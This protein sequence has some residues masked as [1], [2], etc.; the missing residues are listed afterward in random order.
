LILQAANGAGTVTM[1]FISVSDCQYFYVIGVNIVS[2]N[3]ADALSVIGCDHVLFKSCTIDGFDAENIVLAQNV[4][5]FSS[6]SR[7][8]LED[9]ILTRANQ[10]LLS[11]SGIHYGHVLR[12]KLDSTAGIGMIVT[13]GSAYLYLERNQI[14]NI[15]GKGIVLGGFTALDVDFTTPWLHYDTYD[16]RVDN[17][18][19][20]NCAQEAFTAKGS[21]NALIA[22]N[23]F[24][25]CGMTTPTLFIAG[26]GRRTCESG[27]KSAC[28]ALITAGAWGT[29]HSYSTDDDVAWI[30]NKHLLIYNNLFYDPAGSQT[31]FGEL[32]VWGS[33]KALAHA[34]CPKPALADDDIEIKGNFI[35]NGELKKDLGLSDTSGCQDTNTTCNRGTISTENLINH[36]EPN[37]AA[38]EAGNFHPTPGG[39]LFSST[40]YAIPDFVWNDLPGTP[41]EPQGDL[42]NTIATDLEGYSRAGSGNNVPGA[43]VK[44]NAGVRASGVALFAVGELSTNPASVSSSVE[45]TAS[46]RSVIAVELFDLLGRRKSVLASRTFDPGTYSIGIPVRTLESG[47]YLVRVSSQG[48]TIVKDLIVSH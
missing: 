38:P 3:G 10:S 23:T 47:V 25:K 48:Q 46:K 33:R 27:D 2:S 18:L 40:L 7:C 8:Y 37:L 15:G 24:Y 26:L 44:T 43:F 11:L 31:T 36:V 12:T 39:S 28:S 16:I 14:T 42:V 22:Y 29:L 13:S 30:P 6:S 45:V 34:T 5:T 1:P 19:V 35:F 9:C 21:Y 20:A 41:A 4:A 32:S 17:T